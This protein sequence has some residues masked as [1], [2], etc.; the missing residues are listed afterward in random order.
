MTTTHIN[1]EDRLVA[2]FAALAITI[3]I[4]EAAVP[5]PLPGVKPG[6]ANVVIL[7]LLLRYGFRIAAQVMLLRILGGSL[8]I[9]SFMTPTFW[10]SAS[11]GLASLAVLGI[12]SAVLR[13]RIGPIGLAV[14]AAMAHMTGQVVTAWLVFV[15]HPGVLALLPLLLTFALGLGL[16]TGII[17]ARILERLPAVDAPAS[18]EGA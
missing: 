14:A 16:A 18:P 7:I 4:L 8:L 5:M 17:T 6:L 12:L 1:H 3:H 15:P 10:L 9:G 2:G 13:G 11:G